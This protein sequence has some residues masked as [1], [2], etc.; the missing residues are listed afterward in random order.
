MN[1]LI[2]IKEGTI[3]KKKFRIPLVLISIPIKIVKEIIQILLRFKWVKN[4]LSF[5][6]VVRSI[7][8]SKT[9]KKVVVKNAS[10]DGNAK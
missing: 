10:V 2:N 6:E 5:S 9:I 4:L 3:I 7:D 8:R 1:D